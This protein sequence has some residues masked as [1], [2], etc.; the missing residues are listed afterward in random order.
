M[1]KEILQKDLLISSYVFA[2]DRQVEPGSGTI[3]KPFSSS[4]D[5]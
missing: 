1:M 3:P 2:I 5:I 4:L